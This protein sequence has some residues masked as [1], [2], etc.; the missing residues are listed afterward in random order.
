M[1]KTFY[2][3]IYYVILT[4]SVFF[5][6][7]L[8]PDSDIH[9][10]TEKQALNMNIMTV[11]ISF[12]YVFFF[13]YYTNKVN[14]YNQPSDIQVN[15]AYENE[16]PESP[17]PEDYEK[18]N[19]LYKKITEYFEQE[20]PYINPDYSLSQLAIAIDSNTNYVS[21]AI[22]LNAEMNFST[23]INLYRIN[24]VKDM[25]DRDYQNTYTIKYIYTSAGFTQQS[26]FNKA[27][28]QVESVTPTE[29]IKKRGE[30]K[31]SDA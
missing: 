26:T 10:F 29:Y 25:I 16:N 6:S 31:S 27:F 22:R 11:A 5:V 7:E 15:I 13:I 4:V 14:K 28:R 24:M 9:D 20:K 18:Y 17:K 8:I 3:C 23:F 1:K 30:I 12:V 21:K 2:W 19:E